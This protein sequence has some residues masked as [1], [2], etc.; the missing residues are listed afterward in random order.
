MFTWITYLDY[1][2]NISGVIFFIKMVKIN[3]QN[4]V[5]VQRTEPGKQACCYASLSG[6]WDSFFQDLMLT[7]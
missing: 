3:V 5:K 7:L 6:T 4:T 2:S 1:T